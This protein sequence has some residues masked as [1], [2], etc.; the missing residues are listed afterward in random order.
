MFLSYINDLPNNLHSIVRPFA[1]DTI[2]YNTANIHQV[3]QDDLARLEMWEDA[4]NMEFH[5]SKCQQITFS[6]KRQPANQSLYLHNTMIPK[7]DQIKYL[8][9]TL[10]TKT[11]WNAHV[12]NTASRG[13]SILSFIRRNVLTTSI[14]IKATAYKQ[15]VCPVL[16]YASAAWDSA[17]DTAAKLLEA[18]Q[19]RGARLVCGIRRTDRKTSTTGLLQKLNLPPLSQ[20]R[21]ERRLQI[22]SQ[23]HHSNKSVLS[24]YIQQADYSSARRHPKQYFIPQSNSVNH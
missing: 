15:L 10:D 22:F 2:G 24:R 19:R 16:E 14:E 7:A 8:G 17:S 13:N 3:L 20:R 6:R 21:S 5:P 12:N 1:D 9:V 11:N 18:V 4:W 23:Y